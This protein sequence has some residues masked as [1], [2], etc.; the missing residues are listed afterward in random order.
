MPAYKTLRSSWQQPSSPASASVNMHSLHPIHSV[1]SVTVYRKVAEVVRC[2]SVD[3]QVR[4]AD[5][6]VVVSQQEPPYGVVLSRVE[7]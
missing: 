6:F 4:S 1:K 5:V 3:L 7:T 2:F